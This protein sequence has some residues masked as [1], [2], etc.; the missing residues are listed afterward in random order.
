MSVKIFA[1]LQARMGS[2]R[3]PGKALLPIFQG[4]G[5]LEL[6]L[7]RLRGCRKL[8]GLAVA[9]TTETMDDPLEALC[10]Q[11]GVPCFRGQVDDVLDR[12]YQAA[13]SCGTPEV[14][15]RLTGD[16]PLH[17]PEVVDRVIARFL[18]GGVDY[19]SN[20]DPPSYPDG[21]D[22]EVFSFVTL[23]RAWKAAQ[24][25]SEREHVTPYIWNHP[26]IFRR[27]N[28]TN[29]DNLAGMRWT[30]DEPRDLDFVRAVYARMGRVDFGLNDVLDLL[31]AEPGLAELNSGIRR[32]E[33][34]E[35][36]L[37][38]DGA[39]GAAAKEK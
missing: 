4:R 2:T 11:Q 7:L 14:L 20:V 26:D 12:Y 36:S 21:L 13:R 23:E 17:D 18:E 15:V 28:V 33:G 39:A 5:A 37:K 9:T 30:L 35:K 34:Y 24:L 29:T 8:F 38:E 16:C 25:K 27:G 19:A 22:T 3:L 1:I 31:A 6:M 10:R 32:N